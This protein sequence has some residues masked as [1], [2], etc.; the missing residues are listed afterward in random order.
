MGGGEV[1]QRMNRRLEA[2]EA[3][4]LQLRAAEASKY[5]HKLELLLRD[6]VAAGHKA[7][8]GLE[9]DVQRQVLERFYQGLH[10]AISALSQ[11]ENRRGRK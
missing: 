6:V 3:A 1:K 9:T 5:F 8:E 11:R 7:V 2:T 10:E 4:T